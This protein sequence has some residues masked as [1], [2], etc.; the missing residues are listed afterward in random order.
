MSSPSVPHTSIDLSHLVDKV[1]TLRE[2]IQTRKDAIVRKSPESTKSLVRIPIEF[3]I[4]GTWKLVSAHNQDDYFDQRGF[5]A[6]TRFCTSVFLTDVQFDVN[7]HGVST[8]LR[9]LEFEF[10]D[11]RKRFGTEYADG[12]QTVV[13]SLQDYRLITKWKSGDVVETAER[14]IQDG[15]LVMTN[16]ING[17]KSVR[18]FE[19]ETAVERFCDFV[20]SAAV[21]AGI[22]VLLMKFFNL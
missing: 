6:F 18:V 4:N 12:G 20:F 5:G 9:L 13:W 3:E 15:R 21:L 11:E 2:S 14:E 10:A 16:E 22:I 19:R 8:P 7:E 1:S 17:V